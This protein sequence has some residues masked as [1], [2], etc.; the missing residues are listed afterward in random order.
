MEKKWVLQK[1]GEQNKVENLSQILKIDKVLSNLLVQRGVSD[2]EEAREFFRPRIEDLHNPFLMADMHKAVDR[3]ENALK[4][5]EKILIYGDYDVDGTTSVALIYSFLKPIYTNIGYYIPDRYDEGYGVSIEGIDYAKSN[6]FSLII[7]L[8]CGIKAITKVD[9]A[10]EKGIEFIIC[11][12]HTPGETLPNATA[13][14]NPKREDCS[15]PFKELSGCGVG[16]KFVQAYAQKNN[17]SFDVLKELLDLVAVSI[18]S[19]IVSINGENRVLTYFGLE[20]LNQNPRMGLKSI[21]KISGLEGKQITVSDSV[22][23]IGPRINAAGRIDRGSRAVDLLIAETEEDANEIAGKIDGLN[24]E[25]K[26]LDHNHTEEAIQFIKSDEKLINRKTTVVFNPE[27]HK[28]VIGIVASRLTETFYRPTIVL[29]QSEGMISGSARSVQGFN[30]YN[31]IEAC[32][33]LLENFGGHMYAA[34]L[35]LKPENFEIFQERFE[36]IV[37]KSI[38]NEQLTPQ[39]DIDAKINFKDITPKFFRILRQM[40][41]FGPEN[42]TPI[43]ITESVFDSG[44]SRLVGKNNEHLKLELIQK[45]TKISGIGFSLGKSIDIIKSGKPFK[46]CYNIEENDFKGVKSLQVMV[47]DIKFM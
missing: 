26:D 47:R 24:T 2:F 22:F 4:N 32:S 16:F 20:R 21:I 18:A 17:I 29:T 35:T 28:G 25:R 43:F 39:I 23:K 5:N 12:H 36:S 46:I 3:L 9:Y 1:Q 11:D 33:D 44:E 10:K 34:G 13:I 30:L 15:Y 31:A 8:D 41:P 19:D 6:E 7:A 37:S 27:W 42:M 38:T 40:E 14:L 45:G